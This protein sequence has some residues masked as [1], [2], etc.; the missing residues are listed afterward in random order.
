MDMPITIQPLPFTFMSPITK[1]Q[2]LPL[3]KKAHYVWN[4]GT[5]CYSYWQGNYKINLYQLAGYYAQIWQDE[6]ENQ[7]RNVVVTKAA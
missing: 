1:I 7:V 6:E 2:L 5:Y 3:Q 4:S